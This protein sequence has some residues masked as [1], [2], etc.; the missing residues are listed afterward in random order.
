MVQVVVWYKSWYGTIPYHTIPYHREYH[1][2]LHTGFL[3]LGNLR[4]CGF[5]YPDLV[6]VITFQTKTEINP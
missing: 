4:G 5:P 3:N 2:V 1:T 6:V